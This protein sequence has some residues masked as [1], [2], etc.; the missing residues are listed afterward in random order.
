MEPKFA[1]AVPHCPWD[2]YRKESL[3]RLFK[4][5]GITNAKEPACDRA[6]VSVIA[7]V[8]PRPAS[9][10]SNE[11]WLWGASQDVTHFVSVQDDTEVCPDFW[12]ALTAM[13]KAVPD[14]VISLHTSAP[15]AADLA[16]R[17]ERWARCYWLTGPGYVFP[18][19][20]LRELLEWRSRQPADWV[21]A[22]PEDNL[23]IHWAWDIQEPFWSCIPALVKHDTKVPSVLKHDGHAL[24]TTNVAW[25]AIKPVDDDTRRGLVTGWEPAHVPELIGNPW[26]PAA[27]LEKMKQLLTAPRCDFCGDNPQYAQSEKTKAKICA[28]CV[29]QIVARSM[30]V[31]R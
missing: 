11:M 19:A 18:I 30:G 27:H 15:Q 25:D 5:L 28:D 8:G 17:G 7:S 6:K 26:M 1:L 2:P 22:Q 21:K 23:A 14:K 13:V 31:Q 4:Q 12:D 20:K 9:E 16:A 24:R 29:M 3:A 10:W